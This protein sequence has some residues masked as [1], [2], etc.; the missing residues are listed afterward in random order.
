M[1]HHKKNKAFINLCHQHKEKTQPKVR[2]SLAKNKTKSSWNNMISFWLTG[3]TTQ[4]YMIMN[5]IITI[6]ESGDRISHSFTSVLNKKQKKTE[7]S[8]NPHLINYF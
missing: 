7:E 6:V 4:S 2:G 1:S 5:Y 3:S 8:Q